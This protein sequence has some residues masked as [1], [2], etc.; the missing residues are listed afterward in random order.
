MAQPHD[1]PAV[2]PASHLPHPVSRA[3]YLSA[4]MDNGCNILAPKR[5]GLLY[6][7]GRN[8]RP[9]RQALDW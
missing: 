4:V 5:A 2:P 1:G 8:G 9:L 7:R 3:G 6:L